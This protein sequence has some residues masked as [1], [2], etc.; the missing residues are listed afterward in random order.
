MKSYRNYLS[1]GES[2][3][4]DRIYTLPHNAYGDRHKDKTSTDKSE[5]DSS[6]PTNTNSSD[7]SGASTS[8]QEQDKDSV[9]D[10]GQ[11]WGQF[12]ILA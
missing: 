10:S 4:T 1:T 3:N 6:N 12:L 11:N 9:K 2:P 7:T 8:N 5:N